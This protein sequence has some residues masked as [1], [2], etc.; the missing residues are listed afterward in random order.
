L[1]VATRDT[2]Q[3]AKG[4]LVGPLEYVE[5]LAYLRLAT[6]VGVLYSVL[7]PSKQKLKNRTPPGRLQTTSGS[8]IGA[9][10][11]LPR[12]LQPGV[13]K[14]GNALLGIHIEALYVV[15][16]KNLRPFSLQLHFHKVA[17]AVAITAFI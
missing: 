13:I 9:Q 14:A 2:N 8:N 4:V 11:F 12:H 1:E 5:G 16:E 7:L 6:S 17:L 15:F 10:P 3:I